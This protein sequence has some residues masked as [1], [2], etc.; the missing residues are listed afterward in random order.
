[1]KADYKTKK[2]SSGMSDKYS[3]NFA[4]YRKHCAIFQA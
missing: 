2:I 1:M 3:I 4:F